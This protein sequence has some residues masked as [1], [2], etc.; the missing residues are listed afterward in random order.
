M[1]HFPTVPMAFRS[2]AFDYGSLPMIDSV[3]ATSALPDASFAIA[4]EGDGYSLLMSDGLYARIDIGDLHLT[5]AMNGSVPAKRTPAPGAQAV[6]GRGAMNSV[7]NWQ[8]YAHDTGSADDITFICYQGRFDS[9]TCTATAQT[10]WRVTAHRIADG[11][12][13]GFRSFEGACSAARGPTTAPSGERDRLDII[14]PRPAWIGSSDPKSIEVDA[15]REPFSHLSIPVVRGGTASA[16]LDVGA[17]DLVSAIANAPEIGG[18]LSYSFEVVWPPSADAPGA[19]AFVSLL[20]G[21]PA[22]WAPPH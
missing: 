19:T 1:A 2:F 4:K 8:G 13:F 15:Q 20:R 5:R 3:V 9:L 21:T 22:Q 10:A 16:V 14:G 18:A 6:C 7:A 12:V 11:G 17:S